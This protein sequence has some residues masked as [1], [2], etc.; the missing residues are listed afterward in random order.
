MA[1]PNPPLLERDALASLHQLRDGP[2]AVRLASHLFMTFAGGLVWA[3][4]PWPLVLRLA[5][6]LARP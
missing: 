3:Q 1:Q 2:A 4:Q 5:V 6:N